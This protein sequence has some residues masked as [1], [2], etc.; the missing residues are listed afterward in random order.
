MLIHPHTPEAHRAP[1][2]IPIHLRQGVDLPH[3]DPADLAY[4]GRG[5]V[6]EERFQLREGRGLGLVREAVVLRR[7]V[8]GAEAQAVRAPGSI[9]DAIQLLDPTAEDHILPNEGLVHLAVCHQEVKDSVGQGQVRVGLELHVHVGVVGGGSPTGADVHD[10]NPGV[11]SLVG[12]NPGKEDRVH[13]GHVV[14]PEDEVVSGFEILVAT[15]G[16]VTL[17][18]GHEAHD[19]RSH[20]EA[21][22]RFHVVAPEAP[23]EPLGHGV[24]VVDSPLA[25]TVEGHRRSTRLV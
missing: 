18:L 19:R 24:P 20:T 11:C 5:V 8:V 13:L 1:S 21:G 25:G 2:L 10:A 9:A 15:H 3:R 22:V 17:E 16:L 23:P 12:E 14:A 7:A 4:L 6:G